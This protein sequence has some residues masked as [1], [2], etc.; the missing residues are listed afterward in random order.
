MFWRKLQHLQ[1]KKSTNILDRS[2]K[3]MGLNQV[4]RCYYSRLCLPGSNV[5]TPPINSARES[6]K[7]HLRAL[8]TKSENSQ[9]AF[10]QE[11][12][13]KPEYS[14]GFF[15]RNPGIV[16]G[17]FLLAIGSYIYRG[18]QNKRNFEAIQIPLVEESVISPYEAY[19]L[20]KSN[21]LR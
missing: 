15:S 17:A 19:E 21:C 5:P 11:F 8:S 7:L 9:D 14:P 10:T 3:L 16:L 2:G 12:S 4:R 1:I 20:R 18:I 6:L 13:I